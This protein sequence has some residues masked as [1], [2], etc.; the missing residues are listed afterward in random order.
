MGIWSGPRCEIYIKPYFLKKA[1]LDFLDLG[2]VQI[3]V[4][5]P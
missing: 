2:E 1:F 4:P 5:L 3:E